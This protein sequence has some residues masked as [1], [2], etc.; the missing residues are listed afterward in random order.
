M[1][2]QLEDLNSYP[3]ELVGE[4]ADPPA[5]PTT[6]EVE[7][8]RRITA[9]LRAAASARVPDLFG[10]GPWRLANSIAQLRAE[11]NLANPARDKRSDGT[12]GNAEHATRFSDHNP[13]IV[14]AGW[15][16]VRALDLDVDGLKLA[17]AFERLRQ[18][19]NVN[20]LPQLRNGGYLILNRRITRP[21]WSG[22]NTYT[23]PNPHT[24]HGHASASRDVAGF[25]SRAPFGVFRYAP[26]PA[27]APVPVPVPPVPG[28]PRW[29]LPAGHWYGHRNGPAA[30][31]GGFYPHER[32]AIQAIQRRFIAAGCVPGVADWRSGWADG[33][34]ED[35]TSAA[36]RRWF[37]RHRPGQQ[38]ADRIYSDDYAALNR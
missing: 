24:S 25:D 8:G 20:Q 32:P 15:G 26:P 5:Q 23:G 28:L 17:E 11:A 35:A 12:I 19:A 27:P 18:L 10:A 37:A 13:W 22:W 31:H 6:E 14:I 30:S 3:H 16:V 1:T 29:N 9:E 7:E 2:D 34:W 38:F 33:L 4:P 36:A 21:D